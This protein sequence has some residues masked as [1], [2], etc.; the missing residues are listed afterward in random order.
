MKLSENTRLI[1]DNFT[2]INQSFYFEKGKKQKVTDRSKTCFAEVE[3]EED[4]SQEFGIFKMDKFLSVLSLFKDPEIEFT[5]TNALTISGDNKKVSYISCEKEL[6]FLAKASLM[7]MIK[8][9]KISFKLTRD[10]L[11]EIQS[12]ASI[13]QVQDLVIKG[14]G[15]KITLNVLDKSNDLNDSFTLEI[16]P[17]SEEF[18][19]TLKTKEL[20]LLSVD[21]T[22][23]IHEIDT[24]K[25]TTEVIRFECEP[26]KLSYFYPSMGDK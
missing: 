24:G 18:T 21:Y 25:V 2:K 7:D 14:D 1:L 23:K 17:T 22:V 19:Y 26:L 5:E 15:E 11:N 20:N 3:F 13:L 10:N 16:G 9:E 12:A 6:V 4:I 8:P